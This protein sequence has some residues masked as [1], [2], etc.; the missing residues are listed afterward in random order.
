[1]SFRDQ[2]LRTQS[3]VLQAANC[4]FDDMFRENLGDLVV[5]P[6]D[7]VDVLLFSTKTDKD[8]RGLVASIPYSADPHSAFQQLFFLLARRGTAR[9]A[10]LPA[11]TRLPLVDTFIQTVGS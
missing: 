4:R 10:S 2:T 11:L 6:M 7:R 1:M 9:L 3:Q 8:K 5:I